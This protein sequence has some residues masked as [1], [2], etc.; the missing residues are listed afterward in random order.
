M[1]Y[2]ATVVMATTTKNLIWLLEVATRFAFE[3]ETEDARPPFQIQLILLRDYIYKKYIKDHFLRNINHLCMKKKR[4]AKNNSTRDA[5]SK[6]CV[7]FFHPDVC[8]LTNMCLLLFQMDVRNFFL[9]YWPVLF[10][11]EDNYLS[12]TKQELCQMKCKNKR[13][14]FVTFLFLQM[15]RF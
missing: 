3:N 11:K 13:A 8:N 7:L 5:I 10:V 6:I 12:Q 4:L 14:G 15:P 9:E 2:L 1:R